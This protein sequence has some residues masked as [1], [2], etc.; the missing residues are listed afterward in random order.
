MRYKCPLDL[1]AGSRQV[2]L[3]DERICRRFDGI[4]K[5]VDSSSVPLPSR[6]SFTVEEA[7][8]RGSSYNRLRRSD[9]TTLSRG[10]RLVKGSGATLLDRVAPLT[11][12]G[13]P[14]AASHATAARLW[15]T[16][17]PWRVE[18]DD[19]LHLSRWKGDTRARRP[20]VV[21]IGPNSPRVTSSMST[22]PR[23][24]PLHGRGLTWLPHCRLRNWWRRAIPFCV[25]L[26]L[27][28]VHVTSTF[29]TPCAPWRRLLKQWTVA[30]DH[31]G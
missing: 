18:E 2:H 3:V 1:V 27:L 23:S 28:G 8:A 17:L 10:V 15:G 24:L 9:L 12:L 5:R 11:R 7:L 13:C 31:G 4:M 16:V 30:A 29:P 25:V 21:G 22:A 14:D 6:F 19:R 26:T 20:A